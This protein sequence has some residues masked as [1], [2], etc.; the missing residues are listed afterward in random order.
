MALS[1]QALTTVALLA[2]ELSIA[3]PASD[4]D[5]EARLERYIERASEQLATLLGRDLHY[6]TDH[7]VKMAARDPY[8]LQLPDGAP[9]PLKAI[10]S[11]VFD[12]GSTS[13]TVTA[14]DYEIEDSGAGW[15]RRINGRWTFTGAAD[16]FGDPFAARLPEHLYTLTITAGWVTPQQAIDDGGL[17]R[18]LPHDIEDAALAL[19]AQRYW[20]RGRSRDVKSRKLLSASV[21]Y[22][23]SGEGHQA[24]I[25]QDVLTRYGGI[26]L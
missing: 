25:I 11:I 14:A 9:R 8:R 19:A 16:A 3:T 22:F 4:S 18:D 21:S 20:R 12:D 17:T 10:T 2:D 1:A 5:E 26:G 23:D 15:I 7:T 13:T 6:A 24:E